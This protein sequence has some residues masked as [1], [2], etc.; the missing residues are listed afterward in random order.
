MTGT[1]TT[2]WAPAIT[3][4]LALALGSGQAAAEAQ[5]DAFAADRARMIRVIEDQVPLAGTAVP[6]GMLDPRV[7]A[8]MGQVPRH[9][10]VPPAERSHAYANRPL[11]I[12]FGQTISQPLIVALMTHLLALEPDDVVLEVGTGSGYQAAV[13]AHL[14]GRVC[15]VEIVPELGAEAAARLRRLGHPNVRARVGDGY[16]GWEDC[17]PFD[18]I[19]VTAAASHVPPPLVRQ[20]K[21]GGY[22]VIPVGGPY[23]TQHLTLV[24][25]DSDGSLTTRQL[26]PVRFVPLTG[27]PR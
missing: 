15:T 1:A 13:L 9:E 23:A 7:L 26:L 2:G 21:P 20:L 5:E 3:L 19:M 14:A 24:A 22:V 6:D 8:A 10:F 25:K 18:G 4:A 11:P 12:G 17:G 16:Y 27:G